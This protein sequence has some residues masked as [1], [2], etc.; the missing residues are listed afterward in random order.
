MRILINAVTIIFDY[1]IKMK[2]N[3]VF[4]ETL[5]RILSK[6]FDENHII[7]NNLSNEIKIN[8]N[9]IFSSMNVIIAEKTIFIIDVIF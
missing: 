3:K 4:T 2:I 7:F 6:I 5:I 8:Q 1:K 9:L